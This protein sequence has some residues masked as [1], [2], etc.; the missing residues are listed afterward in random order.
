[1]RQ[2]VNQNTI[3]R[4]RVPRGARIPRPLRDDRASDAVRSRDSPRHR[5]DARA[6]ASRLSGDIE[7]ELAR[8]DRLICAVL[9][10]HRPPPPVDVTESGVFFRSA[11]WSL[12]VGWRNVDR[13]SDADLKKTPDPVAGLHPT[14]PV[15]SSVLAAAG[16]LSG[17]SHGRSNEIRS[18]EATE[19]RPLLVFGSRFLC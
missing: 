13:G 9:Q 12:N 6:V 14:R 7:H 3:V 5:A 1:M 16:W 10:N 15:I 2:Q 11:E 8:P 19:F 4:R 17:M 18:G